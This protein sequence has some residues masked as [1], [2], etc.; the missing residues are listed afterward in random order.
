MANSKKQLWISPT[1]GKVYDSLNISADAPSLVFTQGDSVDIELHL[2]KNVNETLV[3]I[4][5]PADATVKLAIGRRDTPPQTGT[6][7][8]TAGANQ[9]ILVSGAG[10]DAIETALNL[11]PTILA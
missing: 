6:Y 4:E 5:F 9:T 2:C 1:T 3:E 8:I 7:V 10:A 11:N